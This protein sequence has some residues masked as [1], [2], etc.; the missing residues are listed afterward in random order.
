MKNGFIYYLAG[1][2]LIIAYLIPW[3]LDNSVYMKE[4][5][6][7]GWIIWIIGLV[8]LFLPMFVFRSKGKVMKESDWTKTT[9]LV[10]TGIYSVIRHPLYLGWILMYFAIILWNQHYLIMIIG[11]AGAICVYQISRQE[12]QLLIKKFG[13]DYLN[14]MKKVPRMN[15]FLG[16]IQLVQHRKNKS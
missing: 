4:L 11:I 3:F 14:Y 1:I 16:L 5:W 10:D 12:D 7:T 9:F 2:L 13:D 8:L 6:Y 15:F